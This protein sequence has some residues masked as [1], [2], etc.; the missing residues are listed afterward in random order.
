MIIRP[1]KNTDIP[2]I[3]SLFQDVASEPG[4]LARLDS[5]IKIDYVEKNICSALESGACLVAID[6]AINDKND[7]I[8]A[9][10]HGN[11]PGIK[12]FQHIISNITIAVLPEYQGR[13]IGK[14]IFSEFIQDIKKNRPNINR[15]ELYTRESNI[16]GIN[17]YKTLGFEVEG[18]LRN[19]VNNLDDSLEN[20]LILGLLF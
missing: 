14:R 15:I 18:K 6:N 11:N 4:Y 2:E 9:V 1:A 20:D 8:I 12:C 17:L 10:I 13:G 3:F 16:K 19:R 5:E 7:K